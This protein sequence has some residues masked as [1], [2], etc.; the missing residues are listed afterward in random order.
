MLCSTFMSNCW[1]C[2][3]YWTWIIF[4]FNTEDKNDSTLHRQRIVYLGYFIM[5][6]NFVGKLWSVG[7]DT[8]F[9]VLSFTCLWNVVYLN[10]WIGKSLVLLVCSTYMHVHVYQWENAWYLGNIKIF[11]TCIYVNHF[12]DQGH[13]DH[14]QL[15]AIS[16]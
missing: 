3:N 11:S 10:S 15:I 12:E 13:F 7:F 5:S 14:K 9:V 6:N 1:F 8:N 16:A 4:Y 2:K